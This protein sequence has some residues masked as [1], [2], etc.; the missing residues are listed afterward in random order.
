MIS[1][2][3]RKPVMYTP[4]STPF[5]AS[6]DEWNTK[7]YIDR[8]MKNALYVLQFTSWAKATLNSEKS[9]SQQ[10]SLLSYTYLKALVSYS[11]SQ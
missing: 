3:Q 10:W 2:T 1:I 6:K 4:K 8:F 5:T 11:V 9:I 7:E